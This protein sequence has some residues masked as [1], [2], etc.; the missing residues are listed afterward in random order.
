MQQ[1]QQVRLALV[2]LAISSSRV[3]RVLQQLLGVMW[4]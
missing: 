1:N 2:L 4:R 3:R